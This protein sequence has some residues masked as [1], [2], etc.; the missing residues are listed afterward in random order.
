MK[1]FKLKLISF[2]MSFSIFLPSNKA[3]K[4]NINFVADKLPIMLSIF[5]P[6]SIF[7]SIVC[8]HK[9]FEPEPKLFSLDYLPKNEVVNEVI[10]IDDLRNYFK[11]YEKLGDGGFGKVNKA[12]QNETGAKC[13]IK[14]INKKPLYSDEIYKAKYKN[15]IRIHINLNNQNIVKCYG[16]FFDKNTE[17][18]YIVMELVEGCTLHELIKNGFFSNNERRVI[19]FFKQLLE[20][21]KHLHDRNIVYRDLKPLNILVDKNHILKV[22]DFGL[23]KVISNKYV[24][25]RAGTACYM[26]PEAINWLEQSCESD[27]WSLG[28]ILYEML[29]NKKLFTKEEPSYNDFRYIEEIRKKKF[30]RKIEELLIYL[31]THDPMAERERSNPR[32]NCSIDKVIYLCNELF[33]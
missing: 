4:I 24:K 9:H 1:K 21:V 25:N 11:I 28:C 32:R 8:L 29:T 12:I 26:S 6:T 30:N 18:Y 20:A 10:I 3:I 23:S 7:G 22:C 27:M 13:C 16:G 15:E 5:I 2:L 33:L 19:E 17:S 14:K 31:L